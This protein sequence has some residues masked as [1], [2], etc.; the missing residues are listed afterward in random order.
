V[1]V[2]DAP[3]GTVA[4]ALVEHVIAHHGY[5]ETLLTDNGSQFMS[6]L[7][8]ELL[9]W[10]GGIHVQS[11][12]GRPETNGLVER[13]SRTITAMLKMYTN[14]G[15]TDWDEFLPCVRFAYRTSW[16]TSI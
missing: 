5:P 11:P 7:L 2:A 13:F 16:Q 14:E 4:R 6:G 3:A 12:A 15:Q 1:A 9:K 10:G 8:D